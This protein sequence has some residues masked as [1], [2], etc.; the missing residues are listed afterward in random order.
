MMFRWGTRTLCGT[1]MLLLSY[2]LDKSIETL[3]KNTLT[4]I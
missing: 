1:G 3:M 4:T 2:Y